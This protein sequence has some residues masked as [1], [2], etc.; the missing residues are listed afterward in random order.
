M[1]KTKSMMKKITYLMTMLMTGF[2]MTSMVQDTGA[3]FYL[4][5]M[6]IGVFGLAGVG[7]FVGLRLASAGAG[8]RAEALEQ[9]LMLII[10]GSVIFGIPA[11]IGLA[12]SIGGN[13]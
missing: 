5:M 13:F 7:T 9:M 10:G 1:K 3:S 4:L 11:I 6:A 12:K 8:K 2:C